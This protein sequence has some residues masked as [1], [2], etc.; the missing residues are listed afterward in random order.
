MIATTV[1]GRGTAAA[2]ARPD[3]GHLSAP[4]GPPPNR[5]TRLPKAG[6]SRGPGKDPELT[7]PG[8][9]VLNPKRGHQSPLPNLEDVH[10]VDPLEPPP[11]RRHAEP[12]PEMCPGAP[13]MSP[14]PSHPA[15]STSRSPSQNPGTL[16]GTVRPTASRPPRKA[17]RRSHPEPRDC[18][19]QP[20]PQPAFAPTPCCPQQT[21]RPA[22][23][24]ILP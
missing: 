9:V 14:R 17:R 8:K 18:D 21:L 23:Y 22:A 5:A 13:E 20:L 1:P 16:P 4:R 7:Q 11:G 24:R 3:P 12:F 2:W 6:K 10:L 19:R 15:R